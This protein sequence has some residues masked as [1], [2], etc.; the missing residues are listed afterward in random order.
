[1]ANDRTLNI[2]IPAVAPTGIEIDR[3]EAIHP[4][5]EMVVTE[6]G[7][8]VQSIEDRMLMAVLRAV[9]EGLNRAQHCTTCASKAESV[10]R[11]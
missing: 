1:M 7:G 3:A 10:D 2:P 4:V 6:Q 5:W 9:H 8:R 11:G